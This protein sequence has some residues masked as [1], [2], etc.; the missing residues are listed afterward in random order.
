MKIHGIKTRIIEI[1]KYPIKLILKDRVNRYAKELDA[2]LYQR[3]H[4]VPKQRRNGMTETVFCMMSHNDV[5]I[6]EYISFINR[7]QITPKEWKKDI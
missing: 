1:I 7:W 2:L 3:D 4:F 6:R 5:K